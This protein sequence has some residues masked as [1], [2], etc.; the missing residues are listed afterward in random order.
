MRF[1]SDSATDKT[2]KMETEA[3]N[4]TQRLEAFSDGVFAIAITLLILDVKI[5]HFAG[6]GQSLGR[7]LLALWP[8]YLTYILTFVT[9]GIYWANHNYVFK[10]Y[11]ASDHI[12]NMLNV[13][14]LMCVS[15]MPLPAAALG[16]YV[17]RPE[18]RQAAIIFYSVGLFLPG[19]TWL[20]VWLYASRN[21]RLIDRRLT[22]AFIQ[23][24]TSQYLVS[25]ALYVIALLISF[26]NPMIALAIAVGLTGLYLLPQKE[27]EYQ[28]D[29][30]S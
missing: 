6:T 30:I 19:F 11:R 8:S 25:S 18:Y 27:P 7:A 23:R 2:T 12:F 24:M 16:E 10:L 20:L 14:F 1:G 9:V 22:P 13:V 21:Y 5:P 29:E 28:T 4:G 17:T 15:F 26:W 3:E